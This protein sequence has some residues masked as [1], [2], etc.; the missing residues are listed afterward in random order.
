M[1]R[2]VYFLKE[3]RIFRFLV[4][5][6]TAVLTNVSCLLLL[7]EYFHIYYLYSSIASFFAG[8]LVTFFLQKFWTFQNTDLSKAGRQMSLTLIIA[9]VNLIINT[10]LL[11]VFV[12]FGHMWYLVAQ[13]A[14][15]L[16]ISIETY[17]LYKN[18]IF[19]Q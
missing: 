1:Q 4:S 12:E 10:F 15:S 19:R 11:Y 9:G 8:F 6:G 14:A 2:L 5:G 16:L 17:F 7:T 18:L 3:N 13:V